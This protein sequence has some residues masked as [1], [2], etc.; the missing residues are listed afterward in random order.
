MAN[1]LVGRDQDPSKQSWEKYDLKPIDY[2]YP[3][4]DLFP[5]PFV[6]QETMEKL[7]DKFEDKVRVSRDDYSAL[8]RV[9]EQDTEFLSAANAVDYSLFLVRFPADSRPR[10]VGKESSRWRAGVP[11][12]DG[13]WRYRVAVLDFFWAK[14]TLRAQA[15]TGAV[16]MFNVIGHMGPMTITTTAGEYRENFLAMVDELMEVY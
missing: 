4:R 9:L 13:R 15:M 7:A 16:Q 1:T 14:H 11:S 6:S 5:D 3:E 8:K 2:F 12:V 10:G